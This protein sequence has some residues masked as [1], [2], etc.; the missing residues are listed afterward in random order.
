MD[1][2]I[3]ENHN[4]VVGPNDLF[5]FLGDLSFQLDVARKAIPRMNG[6]WYFIF[7][8]HDKKLRGGIRDQVTWYG[9]QKVIKVNGTKITLSHFPMRAWDGS[10]HGH[11]H[12]YGHEHGTIAPTQG[13]L[14]V[15]IDN[16]YR[17]LGEYRPFSLEE[18]SDLAKNGLKR[19]EDV[20]NNYVKSIH[21][22]E[23]T[24]CLTK[25]EQEDMS[26]EEA[27]TH[28]Q[29]IAG[30]EEISS[31]CKN[32]HKQLAEWLEELRRKRFDDLQRSTRRC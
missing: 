17:I 22:A 5:Y 1:E 10:F 19:Q 16:A 13:S 8:N 9:D 27:I 26:L 24:L 23:G 4:K 3:I 28:A 25:A 12:F 18:A 20:I 32:N 6:K 14:D 2:V 7:G 21:E 29:Q 15:G 30:A 31:A 11:L